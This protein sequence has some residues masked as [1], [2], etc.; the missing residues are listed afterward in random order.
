[1]STSGNTQYGKDGNGSDAGTYSTQTYNGG[2]QTIGAKLIVSYQA[3]D[4]HKKTINNPRSIALKCE[5]YKIDGRYKMYDTS[6]SNIG[7]FEFVLFDV[8][9]GNMHVHQEG[10]QNDDKYVGDYKKGFI[11]TPLYIEQNSDH[12][13]FIFDNYDNYSFYAIKRADGYINNVTSFPVNQNGYYLNKNIDKDNRT[14]TYLQ[15]KGYDRSD[16]DALLPVEVS[17][18]SLRNQYEPIESDRRLM[19]DQTYYSYN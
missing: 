1:M 7:S 19:L 10:S 5:H 15:Y 13:K 2:N 16:H 17:C 9:S 6:S 12:V 8:Y 4:L 14:Y 18:E 3:M 11:G